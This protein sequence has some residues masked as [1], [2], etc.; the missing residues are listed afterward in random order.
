MKI[1]NV[2][3]EKVEDKENFVNL[4]KNIKNAEADRKAFAEE[5]IA[6]VSK[7]K[8]NI[9]FLKQENKALKDRLTII[10]EKNFIK[11]DFIANKKDLEKKITIKKYKKD[12]NSETE[13]LKKLDND[14]RT[15]KKQI[16]NRKKMIGGVRCGMENETQLNKQIKILEN[17]LDKTNQKFNNVVTVNSNLRK[18]IDSLEKE[19]EIFEQLYNKLEKK[20]ENKKKNIAELMLKAKD[21]YLERDRYNNE[22]EKLKQESQKKAKIFEDE[23]KELAIIS[24]KNLENIEYINKFNLDSKQP[25]DIE[26]D[27][28]FL[29]KQNNLICK[30]EI[31]KLMK[32]HQ[33][34]KMDLMK[35]QV[36]TN[37]FHLPELIKKF[38]FIEENNFKRFNYINELSNQIENLD[39]NINKLKQEKKDLL[40]MEKKSNIDRKLFIDKK[41]EIIEIN[42]KKSDLYILKTT[43]I[44]ILLKE[45]NKEIETIFYYLECDHLLKKNNRD[46]F[47]EVK[48]ILLTLGF[49]ERK[50]LEILHAYSIILNSRK[51]EN[52]KL[53]NNNEIISTQEIED[54]KMKDFLILEKEEEDFQP[55]TN[56]LLNYNDFRLLGADKIENLR[57][58]EYNRNK[59]KLNKQNI[60]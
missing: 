24:E 4:Q 9:K 57:S 42:K 2:K 25:D 47:L 14:I 48:N 43:D 29:K 5:T 60:N 28:N 16:I 33:R 58:L 27:N 41:M 54:K 51:L 36:T 37:I 20:L 52:F 44:Q 38:K 10:F 13:K 49:I 53:Q 7:Q 59:S 22:I 39:I 12:L 6:L 35:L 55:N 23:L 30:E 8:T 31:E 45:A 34:L 15:F 11:N 26:N 46:N 21:G 1:K 50:Q 19:R 18:E 40:N 3:T 17:R 56:R 32:K